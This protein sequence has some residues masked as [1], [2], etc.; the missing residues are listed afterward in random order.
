MIVQGLYE[1]QLKTH[2]MKASK[3]EAALAN[4]TYQVFEKFDADDIDTVTDKSPKDR[5]QKSWIMMV[6][7]QVQSEKRK[8]EQEVIGLNERSRQ[9]DEDNER[10][11]SEITF[12]RYMV[13]VVLVIRQQDEASLSNFKFPSN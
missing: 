6:V 9:Q 11:K 8:L 2:Q 4:Q 1:T 7:T 12:L 5:S 3:M 10:L 13:M